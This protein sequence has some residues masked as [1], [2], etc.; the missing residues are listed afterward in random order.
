[1]LKPRGLS[2]EID[3]MNFAVTPSAAA[4]MT[5][6]ALPTERSMAPASNA[7][8]RLSELVNLVASSV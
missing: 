6:F 8:A 3:A 4:K 7:C 5:P 1:V 2:R